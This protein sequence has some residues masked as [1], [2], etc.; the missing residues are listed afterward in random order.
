MKEE[1]FQLALALKIRADSRLREGQVESAVQQYSNSLSLFHD[2]NNAQTMLRS[3]YERQRKEYAGLC[4]KRAECFIQLSLHEQAVIDCTRAIEAQPDDTTPYLLRAR[5]SLELGDVDSTKADVEKI[6]QLD[7]NHEE[8]RYLA[9]ELDITTSPS[10]HQQTRETMR[11]LPETTFP[12]LMRNG[13]IQ[14]LPKH[15]VGEPANLLFIL[16]GVGDTPTPYAELARR[17]NLPDTLV[18][19]M[20]GPL[21]IP[22]SDGGRAWFDIFDDEWD[23]IEPT[24]GEQRRV[25]SLAVSCQL[26]SQLIDRVRQLGWPASRIHL[27]GFSNGGTVVLELAR[28]YC[29]ANALGGAVAIAASLLPEEMIYI[30][31]ERT[32]QPPTRVLLTHGDHDQMVARQDVLQTVQIFR[33]MHVEADVELWTGAKGHEMINS[34]EEMRTVMQFWDRTMAAPQAQS[35]DGE[36]LID[37]PQSSRSTSSIDLSTTDFGRHMEDREDRRSSGVSGEDDQQYDA[38]LHAELSLVRR[39]AASLDVPQ[40]NLAH[41]HANRSFP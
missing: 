7:P 33:D 39:R 5:S 16:H 35:R 19:A 34:E 37:L 32:E 2:E 12:A 30:C 13:N 40:V 9:E 21:S 23:L 10:G 1:T 17:M 22:E 11:T 18:V 3:L 8:V 28:R 36:T 14:V 20:A 38:E 31:N 29:G 24:R 27:L 4:V 25:N 15:M 6:L 26:M 41:N